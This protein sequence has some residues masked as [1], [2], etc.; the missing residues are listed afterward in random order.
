MPMTV[1]ALAEAL[2]AEL[3][4]DGSAAVQRVAGLG[5]AGATDLTFAE[6]AK[7]LSA[8]ASAGSRAAA[9]IT[10]PFG[11][12]A[13]AGPPLLLSPTPRLTFARAAA[14]LAAASPR[15]GGIHSTAVVSPS[16]R[17][18]QDVGI[19]PHASVGDDVEIGDG[20]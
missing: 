11:R 18:G 2:G 9:I 1:K 13:N 17:I 5:D 20:S 16:A 7:A 12:E 15:T 6:N 4:G 19:G 14:L 3:L 8:A 10:G